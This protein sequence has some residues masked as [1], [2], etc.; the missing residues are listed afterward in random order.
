MACSRKEAARGVYNRVLITK[1]SSHIND[2]K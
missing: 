2:R 1:D